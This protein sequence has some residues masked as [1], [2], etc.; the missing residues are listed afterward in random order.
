MVACRSDG[1]FVKCKHIAMTTRLPLIRANIVIHRRIFC[2]H[3]QHLLSYFVAIF[4]VFTLSF[5]VPSQFSPPT[6][7]IHIAFSNQMNYTILLHVKIQK[8]YDTGY[9]LPYEYRKPFAKTNALSISFSKSL[10]DKLLRWCVVAAAAAS[11]ECVCILVL[12]GIGTGAVELSLLSNKHVTFLQQRRIIGDGVLKASL[13][14]ISVALIVRSF[15]SKSLLVKAEA[16]S[17]AD[18][19]VT[20]VKVPAS[21]IR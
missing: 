2:N 6:H 18:V 19:E 4:S 5:F 21:A 12:T 17:V 15:A 20:A 11:L 14:S 13:L 8:R 10:S 16:E 7:S 3:S 1:I 9:H